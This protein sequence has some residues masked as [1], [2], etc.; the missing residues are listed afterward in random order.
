MP[1][2]SPQY[3][4]F[5]PIVYLLFYFA[6]ER[7][8]W[9]VLL[10][11]SLFF[12]AAL[13]VP[14]LLVVL[15]LV[16]MTTYAFGIW[17]DQA[18]TPKAKRALLWGGIATNVLIL[19][20]MKYLP[21]IAENLRAL[22]FLLSLNVQIQ[23]VQAFVA[24]G[25]SYYVFQAISYLFDISLEIE[26]PERHFGY[27]ALYLT[28]FPKLLQ[29]PIERAGDLIPQLKQKYEFNYDNM[30]LG[31][32]LFTWGLFKKVV[33][34]DRLALYVDA[35]YN[36]VYAFTGLPL[37]LATYAYAFQIY[38]DFSGYTDM[39]LGTA[40]LFNINLTQ[41][42]NSPYLATSVADFWRRWHI[43]FSRWILDY[44]FKPLQMQWRNGRNW[45]T[46]SALFVAFLIS[47][48]WHG[49][50]WGFVVWGGLHGL[51]LASSVFYK[52]YQ[53]KLHKALGIEKTKRL[54]IW[55]IF[56]TF[57]LV[58]FSWVFFRAGSLKE[59]VYVI[60]NM[61]NGIKGLWSNF[62]LS[63]G[64]SHL[65]LTI[66][67]ILVFAYLATKIFKQNGMNELTKKSCLYRYLVYNSLIFLILFLAKY[68]AAKSFIYFQF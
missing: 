37:L 58:S 14:H 41:N 66:A 39:A 6:G 46:A 40:L 26:K 2:N 5:L 4:L 29:G 56:V 27:F 68:S 38:M 11:A 3:F 45:G 15:V 55:Q 31:L 19:A 34:A 67:A 22:S 13:M 49:A 59:A 43:S 20:G 16:A 1:F 33:V 18:D 12:Y 42:F 30:R 24:I 8:R 23:P 28:F 36:D 53:K 51:Y 47:G 54:K 60:S 9:P 44:I 64:K 48:I 7:A 61:F 50:S 10:A 57:N 17:L 63:Q 35:V 52:P 21:F 62:L 65:E 32:L 25:V